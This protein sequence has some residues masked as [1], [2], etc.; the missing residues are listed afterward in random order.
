MELNKRN[1]GVRIRLNEDE[2][3]QLIVVAKSLN[4][5]ASA[6]LRAASS[7]QYHFLKSNRDS[8]VSPKIVVLDM[9]S[10]Q[11]IYRELNKQGL[12]LNQKT[13]A[14]NTL[15]KVLQMIKK[16]DLSDGTIEKFGQMQEIFISLERQIAELREQIKIVNLTISP[17]LIIEKSRK[18]PRENESTNELS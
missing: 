6:Y 1:K 18:V 14:L 2:H 15:A 5:S 13:K 3:A 7:A 17:A 10:A 12:N 4:M 16:E 8:T 11:Q 9:V